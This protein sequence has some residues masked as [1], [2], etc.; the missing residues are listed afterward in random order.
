MFDFSKGFSLPSIGLTSP[1]VVTSPSMLDAPAAPASE[2]G[3][4]MDD[5]EEKQEVLQLTPPRAVGVEKKQDSPH[6][7]PSFDFGDLKFETEKPAEPEPVKLAPALAPS[8]R[9]SMPALPKTAPAVSPI[10]RPKS[11][12]IEASAPVRAAASPAKSSP[13]SRKTGSDLGPPSSPLSRKT[14]SDMGPQGAQGSASAS[15]STKVRQRISREM[16]RETIQQRLAD[17]TL[18]RHSSSAS[19]HILDAEIPKKRP[20]SISTDKALPPPPP[21]TPVL[22]TTAS[23]SVPMSKAHTTEAVPRQSLLHADRPLLRPRSKTQSAEE[24]IQSN[25]KDGFINEPKSAL[26]KLMD[27]MNSIVISTPPDKI[28]AVLAKPISILQ[29]PKDSTS[30]PPSPSHMTAPVRAVGQPSP[31]NRQ[32]SISPVASKGKAKESG[33]KPAEAKP[34]RKKGRRSM[35]T[36]DVGEEADGVSRIFAVLPKEEFLVLTGKQARHHRRS[37]ATQPRLTLGLNKDTES[38]L[39][40]FRD[41]TNRIGNDV[42]STHAPREKVSVAYASPSADIKCG[43]SRSSVPSL[44]ATRSDTTRLA[45]LTLAQVERG[46]NSGARPIWYVMKLVRCRN[47]HAD[48]A[49]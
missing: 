36:G 11:I 3:S 4:E 28:K 15:T 21:K 29:K 48:I 31:S 10:A 40:A 12:T 17:G 9:A 23:G 27:G 8:S 1:L 7:I 2:S 19:G 18:S 22:G 37:V 35:S 34:S 30:I 39:D 47:V 5:E 41:E 45:T 13:L 38:M 24:V 14:G 42:S 49:E 43:R 6:R 20:V 16:I 44:M 32:T 46:V 33:S 26:D 25:V